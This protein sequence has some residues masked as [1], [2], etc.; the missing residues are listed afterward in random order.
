MGWIKKGEDFLPKYNIKEL[1]KLYRKEK[2][3]KAKLRLLA[4]VNR[5]EG[6]TLDDI[7]QSLQIP[8]TTVH[9]WLSKLEKKGLEGVFDVKRPGRPSRLSMKQKEEL[10]KVL[11]SS[12]EKQDIPFKVWT[13]SLVQ[14][15]I[16][17][18]FNVTYKPRNVRYL[19]KKLGFTLKIPR[20]RNKKASTKAQE[21]FKKKLKLKYGITLNLDLRYSFLMKHTSE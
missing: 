3:G 19:I 13:T 17:K 9:D 20:S 6:K 12:P 14:Y 10:K 21:E 11:S 2:N 1:K 8:K 18:L 15:V 4:A 16:H 7:S 5:K